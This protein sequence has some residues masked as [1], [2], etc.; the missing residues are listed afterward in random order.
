VFSKGAKQIIHPG[1]PRRATLLERGV[2]KAAIV[3]AT[4]LTRSCFDSAQHEVVSGPQGVLTYK[5]PR[6]AQSLYINNRSHSGSGWTVENIR[7]T[8]KVKSVMSIVPLRSK[9]TASG[10]SRDGPLLKK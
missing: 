7:S 9:S 8:S 1:P 2:R 4:Q 3:T 5:E 10:N 6:I